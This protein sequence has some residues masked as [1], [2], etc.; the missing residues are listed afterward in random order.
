MSV[1]PMPKKKK[2]KKSSQWLLGSIARCR[3]LCMSGRYHVA[4]TLKLHPLSPV[5]RPTPDTDPLSH[6]AYESWPAATGPQPLASALVK[7]TVGVAGV[8]KETEEREVEEDDGEATAEG[9]KRL[10][11][12]ILSVRRI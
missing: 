2:K 6:E 7:K 3:A 9:N 11:A 5:P 8:G 4:V 10:L 12:D 1:C